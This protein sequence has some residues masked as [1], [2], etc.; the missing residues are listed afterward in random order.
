MRGGKRAGAGRKPGSATK[1]TREIADAAASSGET[2][3]EYMLRVM[4]DPSVD[5]ERR[6]RMAANAAPF[7]H[8]RLAPVAPTTTPDQLPA[9]TDATR[10]PDRS[11][12][13]EIVSRFR[14]ASVAQPNGNG[15]VK[16]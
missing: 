1:R 15:A 8:A 10:A 11:N 3:L 13:G 16:H 7:V 9:E 14:A 4:R 12:V 5:H 6:D 2:P